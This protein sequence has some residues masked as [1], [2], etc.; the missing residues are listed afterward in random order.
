VVSLPAIGQISNVSHVVVPERVGVR[1]DGHQPMLPELDKLLEYAK[2]QVERQRLKLQREQAKAARKH[3]RHTSAPDAP[4]VR[5][6]LPANTKWHTWR[7][8]VRDLQ[9]L[10]G[11]LQAEQRVTRANLAML[12]PDTAETI[13]R[14]MAGYGLRTADWPPSTWNADEQRIY[15]SPRE[16]EFGT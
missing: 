3:A 7:G 15:R 10:E 6:R 8:F 1:N 5:H 13:S 16:R 14:T 12:G 11:L 9:R 2:L 4:S